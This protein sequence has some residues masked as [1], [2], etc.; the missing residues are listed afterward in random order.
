LTVDQFVDLAAFTGAGAET[1]VEAGV[2]EAMASA[3]VQRCRRD[4]LFMR[5]LV[6]Q[7]ADFF[8]CEPALEQI[9]AQRNRR[10]QEDFH[11]YVEQL[12][13]ACRLT[14]LVT[15]FG[16]PKPPLAIAQFKASTPAEVVPV[17]R[18]ESFVDVWIHKDVTWNEFIRQYETTLSDALER[19]G[20]RGLKSIIAY[21]T[22][23]EVLPLSRNPDQGMQAWNAIRRGVGGHKQLRDHLLCRA[24][25]ICIEHDV[26]MQI[27]TG[28]GDHEVNLVACRPALLL[29]LLRFPIFRAC[30]V[31]LV[32]AGYPYH[33]EAGYMAGI[34]PRVY[35]DVSEGIPFAGNAARR[36]YAE[37]LEMAPLS[38]VM[39]GSDG[40][41]IPEH[42]YVGAVL[43][44]KALA[45]ALGDLVE[46]GMLDVSE[47]YEAAG[48]ILAG[49]ARRLY[50]L[51]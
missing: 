30:K 4:T 27:H 42:A 24:M 2:P 1:L 18:I 47:A 34:L 25:E 5:F 3:E 20:Y 13:K 29:D 14:A 32:H 39:Y 48:L 40:F 26:P 8:A 22:G 37:V 31:L 33:R 36:I 17:Y 35:C 46:N 49:N 6:H 21:R 45:Q 7:L 9:V 38:K 19:Q 51:K 11:G 43:G 16:Y 10:I 12:F 15:D 28:I 23:L 50:G 44:K 41:G